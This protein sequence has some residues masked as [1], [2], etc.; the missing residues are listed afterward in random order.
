MDALNA[1]GVL[2][3]GQADQVNSDY[4][5]QQQSCHQQYGN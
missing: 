1:R 5:A 2:S 4:A 3:S